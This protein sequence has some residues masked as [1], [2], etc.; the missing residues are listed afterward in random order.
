MFRQCI[1][2]QNDKCP[3]DG[4]QCKLK[5]INRNIAEQIEDLTIY[6]TYAIK[7]NETDPKALILDENSCTVTVNYGKRK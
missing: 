7:L 1:L 3:I 4:N 6:C 5:L 2:N